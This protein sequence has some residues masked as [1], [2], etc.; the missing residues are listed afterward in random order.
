[1]KRALLTIW[2]VILYAF[3]LKSQISYGGMPLS[4]SESKLK[5][6]AVFEIPIFDYQKLIE[7]E[8]KDDDKRIKPYIYGKNH[9]VN[10]SPENSGNWQILDNGVQIWQLK[11]RSKNAYSLSLICENFKLEKDVKLFIFSPDKKHLIGSFTENN[12]QPNGVF[13][14]VPIAGDELIIEINTPE[15]SNYGSFTISEIVHDYKNVLKTGYGASDYC[16][17]NVNCAEGASWQKEKRSVMRILTSGSSSSWLCTGAMIN[18]TAQDGKPYL[19]TAEH[20]V[21]SSIEASR[22][23]FWFNYESPECNTAGNPPYKSISGSNFIAGGINLDFALLELSTAPPANYNVYFAGWNRSITPASKTVCIHHPQGDI[24]KISLSNVSPFINNYGGSYL[25]N[26]HWNVPQWDKGTTESGSSGSPLFDQ[27]GRIIGDLTGGRA[28]C[29]YNFDD[30]YSRFDQSWDYHSDEN[31]Q[32]KK[33][34]DPLK[35]NPLTLNGYEPEIP[36]PGLD[37]KI[38]AILEP[39]NLF[40][41]ETTI[42]PEIIIKNKGSVHLTSLTLNYKLESGNIVSKLWTGNLEPLQTQTIKFNESSFPAG[43]HKFTA[44]VSNPNG[45]IDLDTSND[46]LSLNIQVQANLPQHQI[47]GSSKICMGETSSIFSA[48]LEGNYLWNVEGGKIVGVNSAKNLIVDWNKWGY[49][50]ID[51]KI[52]NLC[53]S[54]DAQT[55]VVERVEQAVYITIQTLDNGQA[56]CWN[57]KDCSGAV[58]YEKCGLPSNTKYTHSIILKN[59]CYEF[60]IRP[61]GSLIESYSLAN[62]C[63]GSNLI[64]GSNPAGNFSKQFALEIAQNPVEFNIYPNPVSN[65]LTIDASFA[66]LYEGA[67]FSIH[68]LNGSLVLSEQEIKSRHIFDVKHLPRGFYIVRI[69]TSRGSSSK[70]IIKL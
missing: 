21:S 2:M 34:L 15:K 17:V 16:N 60:N 24:K 69:N 13:A 39:I 26:S 44:F 55:L 48:G 40:C 3:L 64:I 30:Y 37:A 28:S 66:E 50:Q 8:K 49:K 36:S 52:S 20:C 35:T 25:A 70:R 7:E 38:I 29:T 12:N 22:S 11:I 57:I 54:I 61:N 10:L 33:W 46:T 27:N 45:S 23:V 31:R 59:G 68:N 43:Y 18:N 14:T 42:T 9:L 4:F 32:L 51:L 1:M 5:K 53:N 56:I 65:E 67:T 41:G 58:I 19:L 62:V 47:I 6:L 63:G